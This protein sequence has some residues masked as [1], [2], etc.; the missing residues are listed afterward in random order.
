M[1]TLEQILENRSVEYFD[2]VRF[3][4]GN[5]SSDIYAMT[6]APYDIDIGGQKF[7]AAGG[8]LSISEITENA[9]F[10]IDKINI[11]IAGIVPLTPASGV[12][13]TQPIMV[14]AQSLEY[15]DKPVVI[16]RKYLLDGDT[17]QN[18]VVFKGYV[19]VMNVTYL[20]EGESTQ[21]SVDISSH[22]TNFNRVSSRY[23]NNTSQQEYF[24]TDVGL[25]YAVE[26]QK[27]ITW[28]EPE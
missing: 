13:D 18:V 5:S 22:W 15:I 23:T 28:R 19:D 3:Q 16:T 14:Q 26:I 6:Q 21:V 8:L 10:G 1:P 4:F 17:I 2:C 24:S 9:A 27:E 12:P 7:K 20:P 11:T 25:E